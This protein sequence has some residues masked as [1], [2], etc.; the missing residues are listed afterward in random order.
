MNQKTQ[1]FIHKRLNPFNRYFPIKFWLKLL[2][3]FD[4]PFEFEYD[5]ADCLEKEIAK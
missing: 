5:I 2:D 4:S 3:K 1:H